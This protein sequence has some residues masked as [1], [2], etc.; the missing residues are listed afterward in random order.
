MACHAL[1]ALGASAA[2]QLPALGAELLALCNDAAHGGA[3]AASASAASQPPPPPPCLPLAALPPWLEP[4]LAAGAHARLLQEALSAPAALARGKRGLRA[5][6]TT[7]LDFGLHHCVEPSTSPYAALLPPPPAR[8]LYRALQ[9]CN[10]GSA[11]LLLASLRLEPPVAAF[12]LCD[13]AGLC[14]APGDAPAGVLLPPGGTYECTVRLTCTRES[15]GLLASWLLCTLA[16]AQEGGAAFVVGRRV[17]A[18]VLSDAH[19]AAVRRCFAFNPDARPFVPAALRALFDTPAQL[20]APAYELDGVMAACLHADFSVLA[21]CCEEAGDAAA[22]AAQQPALRAGL[23]SL[24]RLLRLEESA[25]TRALRLYDQHAVTLT[26]VPPAK[27]LLGQPAPKANAPPLYALHV[28]GLPENRPALSRGD[29][30]HLRAVASPQHAEVAAYV[31]EVN[32]RDATVHLFMPKTLLACLTPLGDAT[33]PSTLLVHCRFAL[34][35]SLFARMSH[36][37]RTEAAQPPAGRPALLPGMAPPAFTQP[38]VLLTQARLSRLLNRTLR[39]AQ[40]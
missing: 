39:C 40:D 34:D 17:T 20:F 38:A 30:V 35:R 6:G 32:V 19:A 10:D 26:R 3:D 37:M 5:L 7:A 9:L 21:P 31:E 36:A 23:R 27:H 12:A 1:G 2:A 13:D 33:V 16:E 24:T 28:P 29:F 22:A 11:P 15:G 25:Q 18:A 4:Q 14:G 8:V